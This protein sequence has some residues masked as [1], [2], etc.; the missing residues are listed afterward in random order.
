MLELSRLNKLDEWG[1]WLNGACVGVP[2]TLLQRGVQEIKRF[3]SESFEDLVRERRELVGA[4]SDLE[5]FCAL[6]IEVM[7]TQRGS[8]AL[9]VRNVVSGLGFRLMSNVPIQRL[10]PMLAEVLAS[11]PSFLGGDEQNK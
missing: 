1:R 9:F 5:L 2:Q 6:D 11:L 10:D 7:L 3:A 4:K 8:L